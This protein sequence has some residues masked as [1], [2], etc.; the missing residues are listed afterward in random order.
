MRKSIIAVVVAGVTLSSVGACSSVSASRYN[1][2]NWFGS[3]EEV[4]VSNGE[5]NALIP[6]KSKGLF[7]KTDYVYPGTP[8]GQVTDVKIERTVS[9][10]IIRVTG[11][12]DV[13][14]AHSVKLQPENG[15]KPVKGVLTYQLL[16]IQDSGVGG[17]SELS[18]ELIVAHALTTQQLQNVR[19]IKVVAGR[20]ARQTR[21]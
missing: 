11:V 12:A 8:V 9:G 19:T 2:L 14:G 3:S 7:K 17:G 16:A 15:G 18:R 4:N 21:R 10:A 13:V 1:P 6:A 5:V 20:N